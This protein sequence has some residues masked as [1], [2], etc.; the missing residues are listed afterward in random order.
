[1]PTFEVSMNAVE[2]VNP[3]VFSG[4]FVLDIDQRRQY[5][6]KVLRRFELFR[7]DLTG[8]ACKK[9]PWY[10][11]W[12]YDCYPVP[13]FTIQT[14]SFIYKPANGTLVNLLKLN[15]LFD[16]TYY[17]KVNHLDTSFDD[18][19]ADLKFEVLVWGVSGTNP[20][21]PVSGL[22]KGDS[23]IGKLKAAVGMVPNMKE[24]FILRVC[25]ND[26]CNKTH[27]L[28]APSRLKFKGSTLVKIN[29]WT[30]GKKWA[31]GKESQLTKDMKKAAEEAKKN[32][33]EE[34]EEE[35]EGV[36]QAENR[37][38]IAWAY[39]DEVGTPMDADDKV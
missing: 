25:C 18:Q 6:N 31:I 21:P 20:V 29:K 13:K 26:D 24:E 3:G 12:D 39:D 38:E 33:S 19:C 14:T 32:R 23:F 37:N 35:E 11:V 2:E 1:M 4:V 15:K 27:E 9:K 36:K 7:I 10:V 16:K 34:T 22:V 30:I 5:K 17:C 8:T 28:L